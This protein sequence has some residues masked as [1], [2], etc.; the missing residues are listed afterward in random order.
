MA[1]DG[2][3]PRRRGTPAEAFLGAEG[4][5]EEATHQQAVQGQRGARREPRGTSFYIIL[6]HFYLILSSSYVFFFD[7]I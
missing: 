7:S 4:R 6:H 3:L 2:S 5:E 1:F